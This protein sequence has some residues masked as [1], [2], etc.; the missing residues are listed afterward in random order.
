VRRIDDSAIKAHA[1]LRFHSEYDDALF[2]YG[3]VY[4]ST[5][6]YLSFAGAHLPRMPAPI[7]RWLRDNAVPQD[8][9]IGNMEYV[10]AG[11]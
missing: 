8:A 6:P 2:E 7:T 1:D 3:P 5:A 11:A 4:M 10:L 9:L